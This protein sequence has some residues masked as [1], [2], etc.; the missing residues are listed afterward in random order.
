MSDELLDQDTPDLDH[1]AL[2]YQAGDETA[3]DEVWRQLDS[4]VRLALG[5][6]VRFLAQ[7]PAVDV[8]DLRQETWL[9]LA[10]A[11]R[12]WSPAEGITFRRTAVR[13]VRRAL[14]RYVRHNQRRVPT[15]EDTAAA[16]PMDPDPAVDP[17]HWLDQL[18]ARRVADALPGQERRALLLHAVEERPLNGVAAELGVTRRRAA[19]LVRS[20]RA[21]ARA[22]VG[23]PPVRTSDEARLLDALR[24]GADPVSGQVPSV[25]RLVAESGLGRRRIRTLLKL[26][27]EQQYVLPVGRRWY[28]TRRALAS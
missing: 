13:A 27:A 3:L 19:H 8:A 11:A 18:L 28:V 22:L 25:P 6:A 20:A 2:A 5:R 26:L 23:V 9:A 4:L 21:R 7:M 12:T 24:R 15:A 14:Q 16:E 10:E 1:L 17:H